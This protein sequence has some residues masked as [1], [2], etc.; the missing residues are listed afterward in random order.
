MDLI[1]AW[2]RNKSNALLVTHVSENPPHW[3]NSANTNARWET[4]TNLIFLWFCFVS[5]RSSESGDR[6]M[7][8]QAQSLVIKFHS[9]K[10]R[11]QVDNIK[12]TEGGAGVNIRLSCWSLCLILAN[13][14]T[15]H[16]AEKKWKRHFTVWMLKCIT[17]SASTLVLYVMTAD[18]LPSSI[19]QSSIS[20]NC[21]RIG[22]A[23]HFGHWTNEYITTVR[24]M[25]L[26]NQ[27]RGLLLTYSWFK[28]QRNQCRQ[29]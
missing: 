2:E 13:P 14:R 5:I 7:P 22:K 23:K 25:F 28:M 17:C 4:S 12:Q 6:L 3:I 21:Y 8:S 26:T 19:R 15:S 16:N 9:V 1:A 11:L 27:Q 10:S 20:P 29:C 18:R 24:K